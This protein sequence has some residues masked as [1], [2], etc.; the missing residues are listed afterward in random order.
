MARRDFGSMLGN[1]EAQAAK[2]AAE[3]PVA[4][5]P[6]APGPAAQAAPKPRKTQKATPAKKPATQEPAATKELAGGVGY[7]KLE[8]KAARIHERQVTALA[9]LARRLNKQRAGEGHR[10]TENTLIRLGIDLLLERS[11][12][13]TGTTEAELAASLKLS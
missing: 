6:T 3:T 12:E 9:D 7:D 13:L 10:I 1:M 5:A 4:P 8:A 11:D 2:Q